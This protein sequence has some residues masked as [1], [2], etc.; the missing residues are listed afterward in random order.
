MENLN[1]IAVLELA[2]SFE[3]TVFMLIIN[4]LNKVTINIAY[5]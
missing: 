1:N 4:T 5:I 3:L 2:K